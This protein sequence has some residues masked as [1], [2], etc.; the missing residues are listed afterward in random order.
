MALKQQTY[1]HLHN[2]QVAWELADFTWAQLGT[3]ASPGE[4]LG[5][6][7][8]LPPETSTCSLRHAIPKAGPDPGGT[9]KSPSPKA[10]SNALSFLHHH[11]AGNESH[12]GAEIQGAEKY[13]APVRGGIPESCGQKNAVSCCRDWGQEWNLQELYD[14]PDE[15]RL[16]GNRQRGELYLVRK[17]FGDTLVYIEHRH[18]SPCCT[19]DGK[20]Q[21][22]EPHPIP[23]PWVCFCKNR[24]A[25]TQPHPFGWVEVLET[26]D[27][28]ANKAENVYYLLTP[29]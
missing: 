10:W 25:G 29:V 21:L 22:I 16:V 13:S 14:S 2:L 11:S 26:S 20:L 3:I 4:A 18:L 1:Y 19:T 12:G 6:C 28:M 9:P 23:A 27:W 5:P 17:Q 7:A 24:F 15:P 8:S